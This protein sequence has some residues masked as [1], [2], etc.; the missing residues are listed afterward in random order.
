MSDTIGE[1]IVEL[2]EEY[3]GLYDRLK[4]DHPDLDA[5]WLAQHDPYVKQF[6]W[7]EVWDNIK[8]YIKADKDK[9]EA[10]RLFDEVVQSLEEED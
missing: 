3:T 5:E 9:I 10:D 7:G 1:Q 8:E 6:I 2:T 4:K